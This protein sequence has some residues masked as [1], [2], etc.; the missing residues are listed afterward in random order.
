MVYP[1]YGPGS[2]TFL[3]V[4]ADPKAQ[5]YLDRIAQLEKL[6]AELRVKGPTPALQPVTVKFTKDDFGTWETTELTGILL[7]L[8]PDKVNGEDKI[9]VVMSDTILQVTGAPEAIAEV[10]ALIK[11]LKK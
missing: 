11:K 7:R 1:G 9:G 3:G 10:K 6:V 2:G 5:S 4:A 8:L